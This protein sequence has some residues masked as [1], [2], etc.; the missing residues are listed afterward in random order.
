MST[1]G[2][3]GRRAAVLLQPAETLTFARTPWPLRH[4]ID[5]NAVDHQERLACAAD[6]RVQIIGGESPQPI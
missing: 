4:L 3:M 5:L 1:G 2:F 6:R